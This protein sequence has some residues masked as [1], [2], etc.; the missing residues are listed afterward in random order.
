MHRVNSDENASTENG[1]QHILC[2]RF[3]HHK[4]NVKDD[5][6][7]D[8]NVTR[9]QGLTWGSFTLI[10]KEYGIT[11]NWFSRKFS[12][13]LVLSDGKDQRIF[14]LLLGVNTTYIDLVFQKQCPFAVPCV[15]KGA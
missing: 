7:V 6:D 15:G 12:V 10:Q 9:E 2:L 11:F 8:A 14:S 3:S 4:H 13:L 5:V 1:S